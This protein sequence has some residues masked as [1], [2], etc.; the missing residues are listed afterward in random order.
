MSSAT[1]IKFRVPKLRKYLELL[2]AGLVRERVEIR[3]LRIADPAPSRFDAPDDSVT[4]QPA[5]LG[6]PWGGAQQWAWFAGEIHVPAHWPRRQIELRFKHEARY[7]VR[8][9]DDHFPAGPEGQLFVDGTRIGAIDLQHTQ[10]AWDFQPGQTHDLRGVFFAARCPC[11]HEW[12][13]CELLWVNPAAVKLYHDLRIV[14]D[15]VKQLEES[16]STHHRLIDAAE[17]TIQQFDVRDVLHL[18]AVGHVQP[19]DPSF[20]NLHNSVPAA[21]KALDDGLAKIAPQSAPPQVVGVG[22]AHID[23]AWLWTLEQSRH[24]CVRTFSTQIR[25]LEQFP[26]WI[27]QQSSSQAYQWVEQ[28]APDLFKQIQEKI[29]AGR[30]DVQAASWVEMDTN[31]PSG[32]SL[33][34]QLLHGQ[35]YS[36]GKLGGLSPVL[37]LPD[38]FG[39][40][41]VLPQLLKLAGVEGFI[42]SK[43]SWSQYNR[44]PHDT[45]R[46]RGIDGSEIPT[47]FITT[48]CRSWFLTYNAMMT[49]AEV[50]QNW[51]EYHQKHVHLEPLLTYGFGDGGGGPT[52]EMLHTALRM[53]AAPSRFTGLPQIK[54]E[55]TGSLMKRVAAKADELPAWDGELYLEYHRGTYTTQAWLKRANRKNEIALH[56][57]EWLL[58]L[59][60]PLGEPVDQKLLDSLW[61]DLL[62]LQFH[63]ILPGSSVTEVY[64]K[65]A[66]PMMARIASD[67]KRIS[68]QAMTTIAAHLDTS[69][70]QKPVVLF[71]TLP[72][73]RRDPIALPDGTVRDDV[74]VPASGWTVIDTSKP[75][76]TSKSE[77][78]IRA[79]GKTLSNRWWQITLD[80]AGRI[81]RWLDRTVQRDV[82]TPGKLG[83][84]WQVFEDRPMN[85][86]AWDI[87]LYY[88]DHP[89]PEPQFESSR[90]V[91]SNEVRVV[92]ESSW[93]LPKRGNGPQSRITQQMVMYASNP[94]VDFVTNVQWHDHHMLLKVAFPVNI[95]ATVATSEI[96]FGHLQRPTHRNTSW[97][98]ARFETCA[99]RFV[100]LSEHGYGVA[101]LNDCKY[102]HD[103]HE[104]VIRL[105]CIKSAQAPSAIADQGEHQFTYALL[106]HAGSFQEA[107]VIRAAAELNVPVR[108]Q[109]V[110]PKKPVGTTTLGSQHAPVTCD[111][112]AVIVD[113][114]KPAQDG[115]GVILRLYES[116]GS[117]TMATLTLDP[118]PKSVALVNLLEDPWTDPAL[119]LQHQGGTIRMSVKPFQVVSLRLR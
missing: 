71:N 93:V 1:E 46:W 4:W 76:A 81:S 12:S 82:L 57:A 36:R 28:D 60:K 67:A 64:E 85:Y 112:P 10:I 21:Q 32:E 89:L 45:F 106:P 8:A 43:V 73:D 7:L 74:T 23:L 22:H 70:L 62:L 72:W 59:S 38:V 97:D 68:E 50:K 65:E 116:F 108:V 44:F 100:D 54:H 58:S 117:H 9:L 83:N 5:K 13:A 84:Q 96:Q 40:S 78:P 27:F 80:G 20:V 113:T 53:S 6:Q 39:Y 37:W 109:A 3:N 30:W 110:Q 91:E 52:E 95:R 111:Q 2:G 92:L 69:S 16:S 17:A 35:T 42:T 26:D 102:G 11:R 114:L 34:R 25:L 55:N 103:I 119:N 56:D 115:D 14:L 87:D 49:V 101:L 41:G 86:D 31:V 98:V 90:V 94:R 51:A 104:G 77:L 33:V 105:T 99:H 118:A 66:K 61:Q 48:P 88:Q 19:R 29:R 15:A 75:A 79:D 63:D 107:G 18:G 47:H 24:K